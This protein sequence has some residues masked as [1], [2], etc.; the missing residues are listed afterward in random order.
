MGEEWRYRLIGG[1]CGGLAAGMFPHAIDTLRESDLPV[2]SDK[3]GPGLVCEDHL[4]ER[5]NEEP[6]LSKHFSIPRE[7]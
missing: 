5:I 7:G 2:R 6:V 4:L 1:W 3:R